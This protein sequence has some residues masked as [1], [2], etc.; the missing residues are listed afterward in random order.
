[1]NGTNYLS[2]IALTEI[3]GELFRSAKSTSSAQRGQHKEGKLQSL[4]PYQSITISLPQLLLVPC[5]TTESPDMGIE[6][7]PSLENGSSLAST[8][9]Q[10]KRHD[11]G[12]VDRFK[13]RL[14]AKGFN[15][16]PGI[17]YKETFSPIVKLI[18]ICT[19]LTLVIM[20]GWSLRQLDVNNAFLHGHLT[21]KSVYEATTWLQESGKTR[22]C[23]L[24][25]KGNLWT[26]TSTPCLH[27]YIRDILAKTSMDGAKDVTTPLST[28]VSLQLANGLPSVDS[29]EYRKVIGA[30]QYLSLT[31]PDISFA[32]NKLSH[33]TL[34]SFSD[35]D[36][37]GSLD[38]RKSTSAYV[39]FLGH[40]PISWSSK[41]QS[42]IARSS[43][44]AEYRALAM[45]AAN[46][47]WLL[48][49]FQEMKF[50]LPQPPL[51]LCDNLGAT[52]LS[53]NPVQHSRMKHIQRHSL[54]ARFG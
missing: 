6:V 25:Y 18:T 42:A 47:M 53:F 20:Q 15:Q 9:L 3:S 37:A 5:G 38:D 17:D 21:K 33:P 4:L 34:T 39:L 16:R 10:I 30:L 11:D 49:L 29:T 8:P 36:W 27:K 22:S 46:S 14:V 44:E 54:C 51:L 45:A 7:S 1:M 52:Q 19:V 2:S 24:P 12:S 41:K 35:A 28:S 50:T 40:T 31:Q 13:A 48:S 23:L 32:V 43:T 26:K